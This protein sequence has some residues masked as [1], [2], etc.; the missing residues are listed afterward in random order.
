MN[1]EY[2]GK[3]VFLSQDE[4]NYLDSKQQIVH[5]NSGKMEYNNMEVYRTENSGLSVKNNFLGE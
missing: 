5:Y 2:N 4:I 3:I 1:I